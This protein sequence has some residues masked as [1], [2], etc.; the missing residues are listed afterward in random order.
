[1]FPSAEIFAAFTSISF[2]VISMVPPF[3]F[4]LL[5]FKLPEIS[6]APFEPASI[7]IFFALI[8]PELETNLITPFSETK[9]SALAFGSFTTSSTRLWAASVLI[10]T[11]PF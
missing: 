11:I 4:S 1:M 2:A 8:D 7:F 6:A 9:P 5:E 3:P 10:V